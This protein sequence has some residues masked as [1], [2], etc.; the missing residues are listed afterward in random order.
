MSLRHKHNLKFMGRALVDRRRPLEYVID[1]HFGME[2]ATAL[3]FRCKY[4]LCRV[5]VVELW[6][7]FWGK[8]NTPPQPMFFTWFPDDYELRWPL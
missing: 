2:L 1:I 6:A 3:V 7:D 5:A 4:P 8:K